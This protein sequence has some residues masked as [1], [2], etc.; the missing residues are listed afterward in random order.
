MSGKV[1]NFMFNMSE[2]KE[3]SFTNN[4]NNPKEIA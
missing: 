4:V 2:I 1:G 3:S